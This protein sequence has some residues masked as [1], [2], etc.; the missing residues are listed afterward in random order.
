[1]ELWEIVSIVVVVVTVLSAIAIIILVLGHFLHHDQGGS[2]GG[3]PQEEKVFDP[4]MPTPVS[5]PL[6]L[7]MSPIKGEPSWC[8]R[9]Y[10]AAK[11]VDSNGNYGRL[12]PWSCGVAAEPTST[13]LLGG[14]GDTCRTSSVEMGF[15][16]I[17]KHQ[18]NLYRKVGI[19]GQAIAIN[20]FMPGK[21]SSCSDCN[22]IGLDLWNPNESNDPCDGCPSRN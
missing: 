18:V 21:Y 20:S 8:K 15:S 5:P 4:S 7:H 3:H 22:M 10:Y 14:S 9:T 2:T 1:M 6:L 13:C 17:T 19:N 11:Y 12:G 16:N